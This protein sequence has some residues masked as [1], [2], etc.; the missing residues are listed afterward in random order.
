MQALKAALAGEKVTWEQEISP[1]D[2]TMLLRM[3]EIH[4]VLPM[5]FQAVYDCPAA[6]AMEPELF[7]AY[8]AKVRQ[9]VMI[10]TRKTGEFLPLLETLRRAGVEPLV[11]KGIVCRSLY[12]TS[13]YR[14]SADEDILIPPEQFP[15]CHRIL[16]EYGMTT[17]DP[18]G[19]AYEIPY[20]QKEG[21]LYIEVHKSLFPSESRAYG[22]LNR[23]FRDARSKAVEQGGIP[24][25]A[26]TE[27]MLYLI[28]HAYKHFLHSGVGI[29]QVCDIILCANAWG[30][31][32]DWLY[33][34]DCCRKIRAE[35]FTAALFRIGWKHL[36]FSLEDS[37]YPLQWQAVYVDELPL[38]RDILKS[39]I[40]GGSDMSRKH[41]S[42]MTLQAV[43]A[44]K[45][46]TGT[47]GILR[48]LFPP[49]A[50]LEKRYPY[51]KEKPLLLP[52]AWAE[53][54]VKYGAETRRTSGNT[55]RDSIRIGSERIALLKQYGIIDKT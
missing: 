34:L 9:A 38:L 39:G 24:T 26:P 11:V 29:R 40:Y 13:D 32:I 44:Q 18:E 27:H 7:G 46:G 6:K 20:T 19:N 17:P 54:I 16:T 35:Q 30:S 48:T 22:D 36:N 53:R 15:L 25:L 1:E 23:F 8:R 43:A 3:A 52:V 14:M 47:S 50:D 42:T 10:Q 33:I 12:P 2:W 31:R 51:L 41:S 49:A 55:P 28:C 37:R 5:I 45:G 21:L 4:R